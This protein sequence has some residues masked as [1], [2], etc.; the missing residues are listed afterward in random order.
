VR[1]SVVVA[2][3][4]VVLV[5]LGV[6][7]VPLAETY[8]AGRIKGEIER[9]RVTTVDR[10]EVGL[11]DR[12]VT[13]V[14]IH[15]RE[16][17]D[18]TARRLEASGLSGSFGDFLRGRTPLSDFRLGEPLRAGHLRLVDARLVDRS[19]DGAWSVAALTVDGLDLARYD[20]QASGPR[21]VPVLLARIAGALSVRHV[22]IG[23]LIQTLPVTGTTAGFGD[24]KIDRL[25]H[26]RIDAVEAA[27]L[28]VTAKTG[29]EAAFKVDR[30]EA[31][32]VDFHQTLGRLSAASWTP[33]TPAG[34]IEVSAM[35]A[36]GFG[37]TTLATYGV[38]LDAVT[39]ET[40]HDSV[41][42]SRS[43]LRIEGLVLRP[44]ATLEG[45]RL[46]VLL[47]AL[48]LK[49]LQLGF[50]CAS[51]QRRAKGELAIDHCLLT[52]ADLGNLSLV[53]SFVDVDERFWR[54]ID[55]GDFRL[56]SRSSI[57]LGS[58]TLS[59]TDK[60]GLDR[61][62][63]AL[64]AATG[65]S[66]FQARAKLA[67]DIRGYQPPDVLITDDLT[68]LLDTVAQFVEK[69]GT[70]AFDLK[71]DPPLGFAAAL[72]LRSPGPDLVNILGLSAT[73]SR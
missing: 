62:M 2:A 49:D 66:P 3:A 68:K 33:G 46:R 63:R 70:L 4:A 51:T 31:K 9:N 55:T 37:G 19:D 21:R 25:T 28:E 13:L 43:R 44:G 10:V 22:E 34:R 47:Q 17:G 73:L 48:G 16:V 40:T 59:E 30:I 14:N 54:A 26:G 61:A 36:Q 64:A 69:G 15:S 60:G 1:R 5:G 50:D 7:S 41:D 12:R 57:A 18:F 38:S 20:P 53:A 67:Q 45:A 23:N 58:A 35:K 71:P 39:V 72:R 6:A 32:D 8:V 29:S 27:H 42:S 52:A 11:F 24:V 65:K 56:A